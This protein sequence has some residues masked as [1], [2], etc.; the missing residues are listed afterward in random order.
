MTTDVPL[1]E[2]SQIS[3]VETGKKKLDP[4]FSRNLKI[5]AGFLVAVVLLV[6]LIFVLKLSGQERN[7]RESSLETGTKQTT[8][9]GEITPA[10]EQML[11]AQQNTEAR[12]AA[13]RGQSYIP[14]DTVGRVESIPVPVPASTYAGSAAALGQGADVEARRR[15]GL[16]RQLTELVKDESGAVRERIN[17]D[18]YDPRT[19]VAQAR[20]NDVT[21]TQQ[22]KL[23]G[24][25]LIAGLEIVAAQLSSELKV[26][27]NATVF[28]SA[29]VN[30]GVAKGAYLIGTAKVVGEALEIRFTQMR[31]EDKLFAVDAIVLDQQTAANAI[32]GN[33]DRRVLE[34]YV[35][36]VAVAAA[37]GFFAARASV[38]SI[39]VGV[40]ANSAAVVTEAPT[41]QQ[42]EAAGIAEGMKIIGR[43]AEKLAQQ[44]IIV[45]ASMNTPVGL[46]FR[47][48]VVEEV[49]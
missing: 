34:R 35:F 1:D 47:A 39:A 6:V 9:A 32:A 29:T 11:Q 19:A 20:P 8:R 15:E 46:L 31:L 4:G 23:A 26:P 36:P 27:A 14:P 25:Q 37:Q 38:G 49:K 30:S 44:P 24:T 16:M 43:E 2:T 21:S 33:V 40:G 17:N 42:A 41:R 28:A 7:V 5:I 13:Q 12:E 3:A 45:S 10:M 48:P 22:T 18:Q